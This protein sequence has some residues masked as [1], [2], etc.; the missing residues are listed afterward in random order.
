MLIEKLTNTLIFRP[1]MALEELDNVLLLLFGSFV[2][3]NS[4]GW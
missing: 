3:H 1:I 2:I 4:P